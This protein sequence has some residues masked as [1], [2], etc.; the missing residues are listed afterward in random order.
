VYGLIFLFKY[1]AGEAPSAPLSED[2]RADGVFFASQVIQNACA[3]QALLSILM[4]IEADSTEVSLGEELTN[5]RE[6]TT[7]FDHDLKG[8]TIGNSEK[9]RAAHN[10]F[11][12]PEPFVNERARN[13][14]KG[15]DAFHFVAYV[16]KNGNLY[17]LDG[18]RDG[19]LTHGPCDDGDWLAKATAVV[20]RRIEK[21]SGDEIRFNLMALVRDKRDALEEKIAEATARMER[22]R[23]LGAD[24]MEVDPRGSDASEGA[25]A[26]LPE[27]REALDA[28]RA[29]LGAAIEELRECQARES[30]RRAMSK[31][32][33]IRRKHNYVPFIF[34]LLEG[35]AERNALQPL[36]DEARK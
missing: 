6:F 8:M 15:E 29:R 4:N 31:D 13:D 11:A 22:C 28:E 27:G 26:F 33:N 23:A 10:S 19:P 17:E 3:T 7:E 20:R 30:Q 5:M 18:L 1:R 9:I 2:S 24:G 21:Y 35:L 16:P 36:I 12:R 25:D 14:E 34:N 32:E